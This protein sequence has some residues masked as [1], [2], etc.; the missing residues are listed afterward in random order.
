MIK[1]DEMK[2]IERY[3]ENNYPDKDDRLYIRAQ[4]GFRVLENL[5]KEKNKQPSEFTSADF[6]DLTAQ[7]FYEFAKASDPIINELFRVLNRVY[8]DLEHQGFENNVAYLLSNPDLYLKLR[9]NKFEQIPIRSLKEL[10]ERI[11][12]LPDPVDRFML[13]SMMEGAT[14]KRN[15]E[16]FLRLK[17]TDVD[18]NKGVIYFPS[19]KVFK[20]TP[21]IED[22][23]KEVMHA[24]YYMNVG[25][26]RLAKTPYKPNQEWLIPD[27]A[28]EGSIIDE[29]DP[30]YWDNRI[31]KAKKKWSRVAKMMAMEDSEAISQMILY[32][33]TQKL[34]KIQAEQ[35]RTLIE[36][37]YSPDFDEIQ[38]YYGV[39]IRRG[40]KQY[41]NL[42]IK[43]LQ[44][45]A[46][47]H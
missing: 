17:K 29:D 24:T 39:F 32:G 7:I 38:K 21:E 12:L 20:M 6:S 11:D 19:G 42:T 41:V 34:R 8:I 46:K 45:F 4:R 14:G 26:K 15:L 35:G 2:L 16:D 25:D 5:G 37:I 47:A 23:V 44:C 3:I 18:F 28:G 9:G 22:T 30:K 40:G 1:M 27:T 33:L 13:L 43:E 36:A 10:K 31:R